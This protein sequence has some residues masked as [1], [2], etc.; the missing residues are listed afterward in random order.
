VS[1]EELKPTKESLLM[2]A[3]K[4]GPLFVILC[5][6]LYFMFNNSKEMKP[7]MENNTKVIGANSVV[8]E[9]AIQAGDKNNEALKEAVDYMKQQRRSR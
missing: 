8:L 3:M 1:D 6:L 9:K 5:V 4:Q 7:V 2:H